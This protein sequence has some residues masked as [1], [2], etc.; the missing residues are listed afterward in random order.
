[1]S[2]N[3]LSAEKAD[4]KELTGQLFLMGFHGNDTAEGSTLHRMITEDKPGGV[5]LF[6]KDMVHDRPVHNIKSP[7]QVAGLTAS[8]QELSSTPLLIGIDQEGGLINR[9]KPEYGFPATRS[10]AELGKL[11]DANETL[12]EGMLISRMLNEAGINLNFA[13]VVDLATNPDSSIIAK[14]ERCFGNNAETVIRHASAYIKG[15][16]DT[17]IITCCKHFP[18][19]GSAEGDTHAGFVDITDTWSEE[20]LEPY[21][22]LIENGQCPMVMTAHIFNKSMDPELPATLSANVLQNILRKECGFEGVIISDDMQMRAISDHYS[23]KESLEAGLNAGLDMF[24]FGNNLLKEQVELKDAVQAVLELVE[25]GKVAEDRIRES[26]GR[27][28]AM[29]REFSVSE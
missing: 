9:L 25:E 26:A 29:K 18:G 22:A 8:L 1:M 17:G 7:E 3:Q 14:R 6:D 16:S 5:I 28:L 4:L 23:L 21:N 2:P 11:N 20:E 27:I 13:P 10:H 19:H 15:H 24:C 12:K